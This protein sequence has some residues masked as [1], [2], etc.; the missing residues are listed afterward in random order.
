MLKRA[1]LA[2]V[3]IFVVVS[4]LDFIIH[5]KLLR[6]TYE[7][8]PQ[9]WRPMEEFNMPLM[10]LTT[11]VF[12]ACFVTIYATMIPDKS[13]AAGIKLGVLIGVAS[14]FSM[15]LG[16]Y[17]YMPISLGLAWSWFIAMVFEV[18]VAGAIM[19]AILKPAEETV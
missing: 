13:I 14:G 16:S 15:G 9:L 1:I 19:G 3:V 10:S 2:V 12:I 18:G 11:V 4:I 17:S 8:T 6:T 5:E 7:Q